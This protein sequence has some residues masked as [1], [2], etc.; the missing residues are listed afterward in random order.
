MKV[1]NGFVSNSST[2]S[3]IVSCNKNQD[4]AIK[5]EVTVYLD[6]LSDEIIDNI[7]SLDR[8]VVDNYACDDESTCNDV[9]EKNLY[10]KNWYMKCVSEIE[11]GKQLWFCSAKSSRN[12]IERSIYDG[13]KFEILRGKLINLE[14]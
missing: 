6:D 1:R 13:G 14:E 11:G 12:E 8:H 4:P 10:I 2:S 5:V 9:L 7:E 3:F